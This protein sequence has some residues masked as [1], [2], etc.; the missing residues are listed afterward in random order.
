MFQR[1][2]M[3]MAYGRPAGGLHAPQI[4]KDATATGVMDM[5]IQ[6][7]SEFLRQNGFERYVSL[8]VEN[9]IDGATLSQLDS[10]TLQELGINPGLERAKLI[11]KIKKLGQ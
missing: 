10:P 6:Q 3:L 4:S 5:T 1:H 2:L 8:F 7:V 9:E 11:G